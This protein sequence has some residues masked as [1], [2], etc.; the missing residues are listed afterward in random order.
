VSAAGAFVRVPVNERKEQTKM[1]LNSAL[2]GPATALAA[3]LLAGVMAVPLSAVA[4]TA[5][6]DA[7]QA[8]S[9]EF[10]E[11]QLKSFAAATL[12]V[13]ELHQKYSPQIAAAKEPSE[14]EAVRGQA[15]E[16]MTKAVRGEGL[17]IEEYNSI[18]TQLYTDPEMA[19]SIEAYRA[20]MQ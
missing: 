18:V 19:R 20:E 16:E 3:L 11:E 5:A 1:R 14:Q 10:T 15:V 12:E 7:P 6:P 13:E 2:R 9:V 8:G 4:Q 17:S